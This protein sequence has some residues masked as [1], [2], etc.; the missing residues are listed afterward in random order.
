MNAHEE[1]LTREGL[2]NALIDF[3][4]WLLRHRLRTPETKFE[5]PDLPPLVHGAYDALKIDIAC[6]QPEKENRVQLIF[7]ALTEPEA[8][9]LTRLPIT[10]LSLS[11]LE[12][13]T[14]EN[15]FQQAFDE[16]WQVFEQLPKDATGRFGTF[17]YMMS[18]FGSRVALGA[19][20]HPTLSVAT[21]W[22]VLAA[23]TFATKQVAGEQTENSHKNEVLLFSGDIAGLDEFMRVKTAKQAAKNMRAR[24]FYVQMLSQVLARAILREFNLPLCNLLFEGASR[25]L[26]VLPADETKL[27]PLLT[28][29]SRRLLFLHGP[30]LS[31]Q[32]ASRVVPLAEFFDRAYNDKKKTAYQ[33]HSAQLQAATS[34]SKHRLLRHLLDNP[35]GATA[36]F[37]FQQLF[38][39]HNGHH[40]AECN[41]CGVEL[42]EPEIIANRAPEDKDKVPRCSQCLYFGWTASGRHGLAQ[43]IARAQFL[44]LKNSLPA[45]MSL[46]AFRPDVTKHFVESSW[47]PKEAANNKNDGSY[48]NAPTWRECLGYLG[49]ECILS[50]TLPRWLRAKCFC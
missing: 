4:L 13:P 25:F 17:G 33:M 10:A 20:D 44:Y 3:G 46:S 42:T 41:W 34:R 50:Q 37:N 2:Q 28:E 12:N 18:Y 48:T 43:E 24:S 1:K 27:N 38:T 22:K 19:K 29:L 40:P 5:L 9:S 47:Q 32:S 39:K 14:A 16:A 11:A 15:E 26:L 35:T 7:Q 23:A 49:F 36:E 30:A 8:T 31:L 21:Y 6:D 45:T